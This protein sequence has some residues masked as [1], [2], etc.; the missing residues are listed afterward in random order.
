MWAYFINTFIIPAG[1]RV[2]DALAGTTPTL[3]FNVFA[4]TALGGVFSGILLLAGLSGQSSAFSVEFVNTCLAMMGAS[5]F[6]PF[7]AVLPVTFLGAAASWVNGDDEDAEAKVG[8]LYSSVARVVWRGMGG[9]GWRKGREE[10]RDEGEESEERNKEEREKREREE[11][12]ECRNAFNSFGKR[13]PLSFPTTAPLLPSLHRSSSPRGP[14]PT[15]NGAPTPTTLP[16]RCG[17]PRTGTK[18]FDGDPSG[19]CGS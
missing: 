19:R 16:R 15:P 6:V 10:E 5:L 8:L 11:K 3:F 1:Y 7:V 9:K 17:G 18:T 12:E 13:A 14:V 4:G 2:G